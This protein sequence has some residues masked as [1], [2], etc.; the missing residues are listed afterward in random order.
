MSNVMNT[1]ALFGSELSSANLRIQA[2]SATALSPN[3]HP[4][5]ASNRPDSTTLLLLSSRRL[6]ILHLYGEGQCRPPSA[7]VSRAPHNAPAMCDARTVAGCAALLQE[8]ASLICK[9][10]FRHE[11]STLFVE[12]GSRR[13]FFDPSPY[14]PFPECQGYRE[15]AEQCLQL[16]PV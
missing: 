11:A 2:A 15:R 7:S 16:H 4:K 12:L 6:G 13:A 10:D 9:P 14:A 1:A 5:H 8:T 3:S